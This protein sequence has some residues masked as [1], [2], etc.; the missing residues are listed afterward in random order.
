M[1]GAEASSERTSG[2]KLAKSTPLKSNPSPLTPAPTPLPGDEG[3]GKLDAVDDGVCGGDAGAESRKN[4]GEGGPG[5]GAGVG[6]GM[7]GM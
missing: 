5:E 1:C 4:G 7:V 3:L 6:G 2:G